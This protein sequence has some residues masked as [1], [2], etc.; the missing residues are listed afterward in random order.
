MWGRAYSIRFWR[1]DIP[2]A[3]GVV[4]ATVGDTRGR[5]V[6]TPIDQGLKRFGIDRRLSS[7][8]IQQLSR[9]PG[10]TLVEHT[11]FPARFACPNLVLRGEDGLNYGITDAMTPW[12]AAIAEPGKE[13]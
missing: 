11:V 6:I 3:V 8:I 5:K 1:L 10:A 9:Q 12:S 4:R 13:P 7:N 2:P